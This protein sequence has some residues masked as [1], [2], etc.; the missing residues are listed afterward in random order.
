MMAGAGLLVAF[1]GS[2]PAEAIQVL[3]AGLVLTVVGV[4]GL[5]S[6]RR[7]RGVVEWTLPKR[8]HVHYARLEH[9]VVGSFRRLP[10]LVVYSIIGWL[11]EGATLYMVAAAVGMPVSVAGALVVALAAALLT[12]VPITPAGLGFTEGA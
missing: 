8:L 3:V 12:T 11:I 5:L 4:L 2:L 9:G 10:L 7:L 1:H 6:M